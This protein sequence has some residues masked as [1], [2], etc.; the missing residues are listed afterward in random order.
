MSVDDRTVKVYDDSAQGLSD[1]FQGIGSRTEDIDRAF[2]LAQSHYPP[3][4]V[5]IGCGDGRDAEE[6]V[7]RTSSYVGFDPSVGMLQLARTRVPKGLFEQADALSFSYPKDTDIIFAF[8]SLLH[9]PKEDVKSVFEKAHTALKDGGIFYISLKERDA[10]EKEFRPDQFGER[11]F[12]YYNVPFIEKL[13]GRKFQK[14]YEDHQVIGH[15]PWFTM[16][17]KKI[18]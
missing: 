3:N 2:Q 1:Y 13:A 10:Y 5:E 9:L 11:L 14:V 18:R 17:L 6:I 16:A 4:V 12:Y 8:A 7:K 15:T